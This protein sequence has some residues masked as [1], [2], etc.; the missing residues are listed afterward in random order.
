MPGLG[1]TGDEAPER[2]DGGQ[3]GDSDRSDSG[4][5]PRAWLQQ[6]VRVLEL[7]GCRAPDAFWWEVE[8]HRRGTAV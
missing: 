4:S 8:P 1:Q 7:G 6:G 5:P 3:Q 2:L